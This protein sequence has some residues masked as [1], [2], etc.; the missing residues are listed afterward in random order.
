[1]LRHEYGISPLEATLRRLIGGSKLRDVLG[2]Y[3]RDTLLRSPRLNLAA[4]R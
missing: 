3:R 1:M 4:L 2:D